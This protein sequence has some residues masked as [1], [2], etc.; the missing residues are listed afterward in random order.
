MFPAWKCST[1]WNGNLLD[2]RVRNENG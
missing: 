1:A 2:V